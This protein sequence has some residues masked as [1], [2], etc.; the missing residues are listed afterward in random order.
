L[1]W[2]VLTNCSTYNTQPTTIAAL[3]DQAVIQ[4]SHAL[5]KPA[6]LPKAARA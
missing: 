6:R 5:E 4:Y 1:F 3:P 2:P